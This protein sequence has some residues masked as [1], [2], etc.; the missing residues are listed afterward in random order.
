MFRY[1]G[2][3]WFWISPTQKKPKRKTH[4]NCLTPMQLVPIIQTQKKKK[5][6][7]KFLN[8]VALNIQLEPNRCMMIMTPRLINLNPIILI[9]FCW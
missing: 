2:G 4:N 9:M 6:M 5:L 1:G 7:E 8:K 3:G